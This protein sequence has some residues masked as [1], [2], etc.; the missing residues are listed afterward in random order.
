MSESD[1]IRRVAVESRHL[2][3]F[4]WTARVNE[5]QPEGLPTQLME[6]H[7]VYTYLYRA[8]LFYPTPFQVRLHYVHDQTCLCSN[9]GDF[10]VNSC[11]QLHIDG[12][13][14][15]PDRYGDFFPCRNNPRLHPPTETEYKLSSFR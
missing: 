6:P 11:M 3:K 15:Y 14:P 4:A 7:R 13:V 2:L 9:G 12:V 10:P 1:L 8:V 5:G